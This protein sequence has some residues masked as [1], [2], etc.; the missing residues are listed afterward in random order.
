MSKFIDS[1]YDKLGNVILAKTV[2]KAVWGQSTGNRLDQELSGIEAALASPNTGTTADTAYAKGKY[3]YHVLNKELYKAKSAIAQGASFNKAS[4]GNVEVV[5]IGDELLTLN[6]NIATISMLKQVYVIN[7]SS[8]QSIS[9]DINGCNMV[10]ITAA[11]GSNLQIIAYEALADGISESVV[12]TK[13]IS[14]TKSGSI[15]TGTPV[16]NMG[17]VVTVEWFKN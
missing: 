17:Y 7:R 11:R 9:V 1:I 13:L 5:N 8:S 15:L 6:S 4:G 2:T 14:I 3:I 16:G 10:R 12:G